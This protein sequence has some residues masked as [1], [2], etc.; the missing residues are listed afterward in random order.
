MIL[1]DPIP[2]DASDRRKVI[3]GAY[4]ICIYIGIGLFFAI[5]NLFNVEGD[6]TTLF[7]GFAISIGCL[8]LLRKGF[9]NA[10]VIIHLLRTN[11]M[12]FYICLA[13][14]DPL[15]TGSYLYFLPSSLGALAVFGYRER[16]MG[17]GFLCL[18][19]CCLV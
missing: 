10:A 7:I 2:G 19:L 13:D 4:L 14:T 16:W 12:A 6:S 5:V 1:G 11:I 15:Q 18:V 9:V 8:Y 3:L 17:I